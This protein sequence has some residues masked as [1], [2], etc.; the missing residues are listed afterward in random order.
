MGGPLSGYKV[1]ELAGIGP[2]P[3]AGMLLAELGADVITVDRLQPSG[4]G[5]AATASDRFNLLRRSRPTVQVDLKNPKGKAL[6]LDLVKQADA[7]IEGFRPGVTERLGLGPDDCAAVNPKL[8]YGRVTGWGQD[9]PISQRQVDIDVFPF[10]AMAD[11][12]NGIA[13]WQIY[14]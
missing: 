9:G 3:M 11:E 8:V 14:R 4:L 6:V 7:L 12:A 5:T 1:V 13:P 10:R 2:G